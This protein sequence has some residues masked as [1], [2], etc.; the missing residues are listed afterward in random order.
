MHSAESYSKGAALREMAAS[1]FFDVAA[2]HRCLFAERPQTTV[3]V[4][5]LDTSCA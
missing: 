4:R 2:R 5:A 1:P 3:R